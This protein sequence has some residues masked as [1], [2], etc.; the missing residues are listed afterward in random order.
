MHYPS[1]NL[2]LPWYSALALLWHCASTTLVC[3]SP[4]KVLL[5]CPLA[6]PWCCPG[7]TFALAPADE[8]ALVLWPGRRLPDGTVI[9]FEV[10][11]REHAISKR[12]A[13][14]SKTGLVQVSTTAAP[15]QY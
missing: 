2:V 11:M 3:S 10:R 14:P 9:C 4:A 7:T 12:V 15:W 13:A 5:Q 8:L 1:T 6:R